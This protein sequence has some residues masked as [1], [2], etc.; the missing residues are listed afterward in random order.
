MPNE[1]D[2][3]RLVTER[4]GGLDIPFMLTGSLAMAYYATPRMT[5]DLDLIVAPQEA[6]VGKLVGE[7][8][9]DFYVDADAA[10]DAVRSNRLFN[11]MHLE[12]GIK[13]DMI[14]KKSTPYRDLEFSRRASGV[15]G[16]VPT[17]LVSREDLI[18]SKLIWARDSGSELQQRDVRALLADT[19]DRPYLKLWAADL[20]VTDLLD[21]LSR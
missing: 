20:G 10:R 14:I 6:D 8:A 11:M 13:L 12:S 18:L 9:P 17:W 19:V 15:L 5:R 7:F 21:R 2:V 4:L 16:G 1:L 3:L